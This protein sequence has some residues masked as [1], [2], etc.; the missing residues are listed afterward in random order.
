MREKLFHFLIAAAVPSGIL[1]PWPTFPYSSDCSC[2]YLILVTPGLGPA[3]TAIGVPY[4][5]YGSGHCRSD[6][7]PRFLRAEELV[8]CLAH[9]K[10]FCL[11]MACPW[12]VPSYHFSSLLVAQLS[13]PVL[14]PS[15]FPSNR[16]IYFLLG[17]FIF[18]KDINH[19]KTQSK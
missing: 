12:P 6:D 4:V 19:Q 5:C 8:D 3:L 15:F 18:M 1:A 16:G 9:A 10:G 13:A 7:Q 17:I 11:P 14:P 2:L